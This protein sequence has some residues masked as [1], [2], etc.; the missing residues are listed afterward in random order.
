MASAGEKFG[1]YVLIEKI[2]EGGFSEVWKGQHT[3]L[4]GKC[5]AIKIPTDSEYAARLRSEADFQH[6]LSNP[7]IVR[8]ET[9]NTSSD[10]PYMV[11]E[12]MPGGSLRD[13]L[14]KGP[15]DLQTAL[16]YMQGVLE[17][18]SYAHANAVVHADIKP[19]NVL[20]D[21]AW[22]IKIADFGLGRLSQKIT[23]ERMLRYRP[24]TQK[25]I[26]TYDYMA[27]EVKRGDEPTQQSDVYSCGIVFYELL[28]GVTR[29]LEFPVEK[30]EEATAVIKKAVRRDP[31][32]RYAS[33][34]EMLEELYT[35][36][37]RPS[38]PHIYVPSRPVMKVSEFVLKAESGEKDFRRIILVSDNGTKPSVEVFRRMENS[39]AISHALTDNPDVPVVSENKRKLNTPGLILDGSDFSC[40]V[41]CDADLS[42]VRA[43]KANFSYSQM[44]GTS[45]HGA[46]LE[47]A[48]F[49]GT[50][51]PDLLT[52]SNLKRADFNRACSAF[53]DFSF[54]DLRG[55][56]NLDKM[57]ALGGVPKFSYT[58]VTARERDVLLRFLEEKGIFIVESS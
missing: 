10:R 38:G 58:L 8:I 28:T 12:F 26:G 46:K 21:P 1:D 13:K 42:H 35:A 44:I 3:E 19:E 7:R 51:L 20:F 50:M 47:E 34:I 17:G 18:L 32:E 55:A 15:L 27:P 37:C 54:S 36:F 31:D 52:N 33:A 48:I 30:S 39:V 53:T 49:E 2:G 40:S 4:D 16:R 57:E 41:I 43:R 29:P 6:Q 56:F 5:M 22:N 9:V 25:A 45:M 11:M 14:S 23:S 24:T